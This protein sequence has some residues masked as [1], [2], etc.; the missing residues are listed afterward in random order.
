MRQIP[1]VDEMLR[2][3]AVEAWAK[4]R[5]RAVMVEAIRGA[6]ADLR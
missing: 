2:L 4:S 1:A 5:P 6:L 3:P